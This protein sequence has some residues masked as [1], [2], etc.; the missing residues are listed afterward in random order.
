VPTQFFISA[1]GQGN[2]IWTKEQGGSL[3]RLEFDLGAANAAVTHT[4]PAAQFASGVSPIAIDPVTGLLAGVNVRETPDNL[5]LYDVSDL[6]AGPA[7]L[8]LE[9]FATDNANVN[10]TGAVAFGNGFVYALDTNNGL[11]AQQVN[12]G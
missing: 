8:D 1:F 3:K 2:T 5:R 10:A 12:F 11:V 4:F 9:F 7:L 6:E